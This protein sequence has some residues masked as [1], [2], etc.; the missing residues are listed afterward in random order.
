MWLLLSLTFQTGLAQPE[1]LFFNHLTQADGLSQ[2]TN[3]IVFTDSRGF[4]WI[5]S[6]NGL[7]RYDGQQ[8]KVYKYR[9]GDPYSLPDNYIQSRIIEDGQG[10]L[11]FSTYE[12]LVRYERKH[13]RF[14]SYTVPVEKGIP[15][16]GYRLAFQ[17]RAWQF[18]VVVQGTQ[19]WLFDSLNSEWCLEHDLPTVT[20]RVVPL[21]T[22]NGTC[23]GL[24]TFSYDQQ[25][26]HFI[27][28]N[29]T[30]DLLQPQRFIGSNGEPSIRPTDAL[31]EGDSLLRVA[32][33]E[34]FLTIGLK[35]GGS[36][37]FH[38]TP[39]WQPN[40]LDVYEQGQLLSTLSGGGW[41][42]APKDSLHSGKRFSH[43]P[44]NPWSLASNRTFGI[45]RDRN[46]V[47]WTG[48]TGIGVD[49]TQPAKVK[50]NLLDVGQL[51]SITDRPTGISA[52][53]EDRDGNTW[54]ASRYGGV[55][56]LSP[57]KQPL[58]HFSKEEGLPSNDVYYFFI[59]SE[60][61]H[62]ALT[63]SGLGLLG[64]NEKS[65]R[66]IAPGM[67]FLHGIELK[68]GK[69]VLLSS[70]SKE[71]FQVAESSGEVQLRK[72]PQFKE[73]GAY[74]YFF[75]AKNG[76]L[77]ACRDLSKIEVRDPDNNFKLIETHPIK[78]DV[79]GF[80]EEP[81][82]GILWIA[83][84]NGLVK[85]TPKIPI[86][87][88][89]TEADGLP[90]QHVY[91]ILP[92][93]NGTFWLTTNRGMVQFFPKENPPRF[94]AFDIPDGL[95]GLEFNS[96]GFLR[97]SN[98]EF[99]FA[100]QN[101]I[102]YF[103][104]D[105]IR[106]LRHLPQVQFTR[107]YVNDNEELRPCA[108]TGATNISEAT[109][110]DFNWK[111]NTLS[112]EFAALEFSNPSKNTFQYMM[113][114]Y[115]ESWVQGGTRGF[116]RYANLPP[117]TYTFKVRATNSDGQLS[118]PKVLTIAIAPPWWKQWWFVSLVLAAL[119]TTGYG[120]YRWRVA[121]LLRIER[122]RNQISNDLHDDIGATLSNVNILTTLIRQ[123]LPADSEALP[124]LARIE[125]EVLASAESL[126]DIIWSINPQ[127]DP[128]DRV[129]A[130]MRRFA[131]EAFEAK[132]I[133]GELRFPPQAKRLRLDMDKRRQFYLFFKEAVNN[134]VKYAACKTALINVEFDQGKLNVI[135]K[136]DGVGF[137]LDAVRE[138][139]NGLLT[140]RQRAKNLRG[141][142][143]IQSVPG[144]GTTVR[145]SFPITEISD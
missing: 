80:H 140:M 93:E 97:R 81:G 63:F 110:L 58:A 13:D 39:D 108:L 71:V 144:E 22:R 15:P 31:A 28:Y 65:F 14:L 104:P 57:D 130:R 44:G 16:K 68:K 95:Q 112:F 7:N 4:V 41:T 102:N 2:A 78:G 27:W 141:A 10:D 75:Q 120:I 56:V 36:W 17:G 142:F 37:Q 83:T 94:H 49:F 55:F 42:I 134:L 138:S 114:G 69:G 59:D 91:A 60:N 8:V 118:E 90:D 45:R 46:G 11:W 9:Q 117:K 82:S 89:F 113:V 19:L 20:H 92:D 86:P 43:E 35:N 3:N 21:L 116:A 139:G 66:T 109:K 127:N 99:W 77:Y 87:Q 85:L 145:V 1:R 67:G 5:S 24:A 18:A 111:E 33:R 73:G 103:I 50:F 143:D 106:L 129:L 61:R 23:T 125:E 79:H 54:C 136:D 124:L 48:V 64:P 76:W 100:G 40:D 122:L 25:G 51:W 137:N 6:I 96:F 131:T 123:R 107:L 26:I 70:L 119:L 88:T 53:A 34:G 133:A 30:K 52:M 132:G 121:H 74:T 47:I 135:I 38:P 128:L 126:D 84:G 98:R 32:A 101:G 115:D 12:A 72:M 62:W 29:S 105:S